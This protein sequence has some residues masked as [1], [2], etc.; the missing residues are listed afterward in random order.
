MRTSRGFS[1]LEAL[2]ASILVALAAMAGAAHVTRSSQHSD[3]ARD[4]AFARQKALSVLAELRAYV[5]GGEGE[6]AADLDGLDDGL[7]VVPTLTIAAD[8]NLPGTLVAPEHPLSGNIMDSGVWR[9]QRRITVRRFPGVEARDLRIVTVRV[10]RTRPADTLPG[11]AMAEVSSVIRTVG[12][13]YPTAQV[14]DVYLLALEN[15]PGWWVYM[16]AIQPFVEATLT[17]L[18]SRNPGLTFRTH[19]ITKLGYGRDEEYAPATNEVRDSRANTP[20]TYVYPGSMPAGFAASRYYPAERFSARVNLDGEW[21][22]TFV[23][24]HAAAEPFTDG[25]GDGVYDPGETFTDGDGDGIR[26]AGNPWPYALADQHNHCMRS[27][28]EVARFEA[29]RA[30]GLEDEGTPTWRLLLDRMVSEPDRFHNAILVN[31]H[32]EL[33]PLPP[34]RNVSDAAKDPAALPGWRAVTHPERIRMARVAGNDVLSTRPRWRVHAWKTVFPSPEAL[35]TQPEPF[36]DSDGDGKRSGVEAYQD[37]NADGTH[38]VGVPLSV[39]IPGGDFSQN[40]N[41]TGFVP[42]M[43][44]RLAGGVDADGSGAADPYQAFTAASRYPEEWKDLDSDGRRQVAELW[45]DLDGDAAYTAGEPHQDLDGDGIYTPASEP[46][47]DANGNGRFDAATPAEPFTDLD[48]DGVWDAPEPYD[49]VDANGAWTPA[50]VPVLPWRA[51]NPAIDNL[52][53][54]SRAVYYAAYGE[55]FLDR[56]GD[57]VRDAGEVLF[58]CDQDGVHDGGFRRGEMWFGATYDAVGDRTVLTL[59]GTP[60]ECPVVSS[61]GLPSTWRLY[62]LD[63]VPCPTPSSLA[64]TNRFAR[65]LFTTGSFPKNT[66]RWVIEMTIPGLRQALESA[67]GANDG[68]ATDQVLSV[69]TR[70]G[71]DLATGVRWPV[72][73]S[74]ANLSRSYAWY[75]DSLTDV[76]FSERYQFQGDPRHSPYADT[77]ATGASFPHGYNWFFDDQRNGATNATAS[78]LAFDPARIKDGWNKYTNGVDFG[79]GSCHDVGRLMAWM[80]TAITS[81]EALYTTLTGF[82]NYYLS[83]GGD[84]GYDSANGFANSIP[85]DGAPFGLASDVYENTITDGNGDAAL[86]GSLKLVRSNTGSTSASLRSGGAW[87]SK[88]WLGELYPDA[89]YASQWAPWGNLRAGTA[90][91]TARLIRRDAVPSGQLPQGTTLVRA[92]ARLQDSGCT[93]FF[94]IGT[95][96]PHATFHHQY[97]DG[98][99]GTLVEDGPELAQRYGF[100]LSTTAAISRPFGLALDSSGL[101]GSEFPYATEYPRFAAQLVRRF[102]SHQASPTLVGSGLV[103]LQQ[104]GGARGGYIVVNGIDKTTESGSAFIARYSMLS[105]THSYF[106]AGLPGALNR[107]KQLPRVQILTPTLITELDNPATIELRW[108]SA[109]RRWDGQ[110]YTTSHPAGFAEDESALVYVIMLSRDGG[111]EWTNLLDDS[112]AEPGV[113]PWIDGVGADPARTRPDQGT[114]ADE[115]FVWNTPAADVPEGTYMLRIEAYRGGEALHYA[116]HMERIYVDR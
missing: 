65:D 116:Q 52:S 9:W 30:A 69:E 17:D 51:W 96:S 4:K 14:Y 100:P 26:D 34:A 75:C 78:W 29:R 86:N 62:D 99:N 74:P 56:D 79:R 115:V 40:I 5:E 50:T 46:L 113:L 24:G 59:W 47:T 37:W 82:S 80:R 61:A 42:L 31:L 76:P 35:M 63:Y 109:W 103:R 7:A 73:N 94:N 88:P 28:D 3:W 85:M 84:V 114:G 1:L 53:P 89:V 21:A 98:Q 43:V 77:D 57:S 20:W 71:T 18:E 27:P 19:W 15:V 49:D 25:D 55:P 32:G 16:D 112:P 90:A 12:D 48:A 105:L 108:S 54:A 45:L 81:S 101:Q 38:D 64:G 92:H 41:G 11:E 2:M 6:V 33:L 13:S 36:L 93:S 67:P 107:V 68:D 60:L 23:G 110:P 22:P 97:Q 95:S 8:P 102:Y 66:A 106:A 44:T 91:G 83:L 58:D 70:L 104:P 72:A 111:R 39:T 10:F 87:W